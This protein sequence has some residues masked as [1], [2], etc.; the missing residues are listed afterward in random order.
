MGRKVIKVNETTAIVVEPF[1][2][3]YGDYIG[4]REFYKPKSDLEG[5]WRPT[6]KGFSIPMP[7]GDEDGSAG[8]DVPKKVRN[9]IKWA[10]EN[11]EEEHKV[12]ESTKG[13]KSKKKDEEDEK[14]SKKK[15]KK[16]SKKSKDEDEE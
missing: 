1:K 5:D 10:V 3:Q 13:P 7:D 15:D 6:Q 14:P 12:L 8:K 9:A 2:N 4:V 11:F 16:K